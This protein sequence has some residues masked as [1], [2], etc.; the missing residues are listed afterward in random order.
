[1]CKT[2]GRGS[3][4]QNNL[5]DA[6]SRSVA[7]GPCLKNGVPPMPR[8]KI[9][10][11][12]TIHGSERESSKAVEVARLLIL[13]A[14]KICPNQTSYLKVMNRAALP[15][16]CL[17]C[18]RIR[19]SHFLISISISAVSRPPSGMLRTS[20]QSPPICML[21]LLRRGKRKLV[22]F[23]PLAY[24]CPS[25]EGDREG[26]TSL[27]VRTWYQKRKGIKP[28]NVSLLNPLGCHWPDVSAVPS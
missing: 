23:L 13:S 3:R 22:L 7:R 17:S 26:N 5:N 6:T 2:G 27:P 9:R 28:A 8:L 20:S 10:Q 19:S 11:R 25:S 12:Y 15:R 4:E 14:N 16:H 24:G 21:Q 1:M 18:P